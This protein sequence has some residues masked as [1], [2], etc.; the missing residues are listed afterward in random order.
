MIVLRYFGGYTL[1]ETA[2][3]LSIPAGTVSTRQRRA[4]EL[5]RLDLE[6]VEP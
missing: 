2:E 1:A 5:L 6:E 3:I 4:L